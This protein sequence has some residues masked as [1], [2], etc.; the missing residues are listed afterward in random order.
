MVTFKFT[1]NSYFLFTSPATL[2]KAIHVWNNG[3]VLRYKNSRSKQNV[4]WPIANSSLESLIK[5]NRIKILTDSEAILWKL[6]N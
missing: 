2:M 5:Q 3:V 4:R 1:C 6:E